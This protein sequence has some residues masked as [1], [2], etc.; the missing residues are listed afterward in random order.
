MRWL[1]SRP[2]TTTSHAIEEMLVALRRVARADVG[3][4]LREE[5]DVAGKRLLGAD[6]GG[7]RLVLHADE[8]C[9]IDAYGTTLAD[10]DRDDVA[11]EPDDVVREEGP[12]H[13]LVDPGDGRRLE[14]AQIDVRR[15]EDLCRG[16]LPSSRD[17]DLQNSRMRVAG[18]G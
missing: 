14:R 2:E 11:D 15:R 13:P 17:V 12:P 16:K 6:D 18:S 9:G 5:Q 8:I 1:T 3:P 10:D 4:R 7:Q